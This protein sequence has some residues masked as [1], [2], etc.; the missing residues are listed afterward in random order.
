MLTGKQHSYKQVRPIYL[1]LFKIRLPIPGLV[2]FLHRMSGVLLFL[3]IPGS[4]F[5]LELSLASDGIGFQ[6]VGEFLKHPLMLLTEA[7]LLW[8]LLHH[9]FSGIR[10]LLM[11]AGWGFDRVRSFQTAWVVL[12]TGIILTIVIM[13]AVWLMV[14]L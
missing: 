3:A 10:F 14:W 11:D 2:S 12:V 13:L 6:Q 5:L 1:N 7:I 4:I 8:S 9:S